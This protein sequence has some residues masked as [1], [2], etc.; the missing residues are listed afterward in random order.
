MIHCWPQL[1]NILFVPFCYVWYI[2]IYPAE[3]YTFL[4]DDEENDDKAEV[5]GLIW[6]CGLLYSKFSCTAHLVIN[7]YVSNQIWPE[8]LP[9]D[10]ETTTVPAIDGMKSKISPLIFTK[11]YPGSVT[12]MSRDVFPSI[13]CVFFKYLCDTISYFE[14]KIE[15]I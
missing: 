11:H 14:Q 3:C 6:I 5:S 1:G 13:I 15:V 8:V 7:K 4:F 10:D 9:A 12:L 2:F